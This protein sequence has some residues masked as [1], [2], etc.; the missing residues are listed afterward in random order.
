MINTI[1]DTAFFTYK[2]FKLI[3][4]LSNNPLSNNT[5]CLNSLPQTLINPSIL[6][7]LIRNGFGPV[8]VFYEMSQTEIFLYNFS[9]NKISIK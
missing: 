2:I 1:C 7:N 6:S 9:S 8:E 4:I 3:I 5:K